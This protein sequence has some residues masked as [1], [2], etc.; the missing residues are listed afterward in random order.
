VVVVV[1]VGVG[2]AART[3][4]GIT[5]GPVGAIKLRRDG[6][7]PP[8]ANKA[9][10]GSTAVV[11]AAAVAGTTAAGAVGLVGTVVDLRGVLAWDEES[12]SNESKLSLKSPES[13][14]MVDRLLLGATGIG[15]AAAVTFAAVVAGVDA[16]G[17][18][19]VATD[20]GL[21]SLLSVA[22]GL[23]TV[24]VEARTGVDVCVSATSCVAAAVLVVA[25]AAAV[26]VRPSTGVVS[27][28]PADDGVVVVV[29]VV[30][31]AAAGISPSVVLEKR[32][33]CFMRAYCSLVLRRCRS[34]SDKVG[35]PAAA[36][37]VTGVGAAPDATVGS[38]PPE[39]EDDKVGSPGLVRLSSRLF[40]R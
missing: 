9:S 12:G 15:V 30:D 28:A 19:T 21:D 4:A 14:L 24:V 34:A 35:V 40:E 13:S 39:E 7:F 16:A 20:T 5:T 18:A 31:V 6:R 37:V 3:D 25:N 10:N 33:C 11:V 27:A 32:R 1:G 17:A 36:A 23:A 38:E 26:S 29:V 8:P 2:A 22:V